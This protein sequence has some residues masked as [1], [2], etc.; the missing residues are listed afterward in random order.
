[1]C[2]LLIIE[3]KCG[4]FL[5]G[6]VEHNQGMFFLFQ[7]LPKVLRAKMADPR[8]PLLP[9]LL[10]WRGGLWTAETENYIQLPMLKKENK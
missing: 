7:S 8:G 6:G 5:T 4:S 3:G 2:L 10:W 1:M 9:R